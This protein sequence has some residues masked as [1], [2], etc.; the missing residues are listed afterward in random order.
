LK[1]QQDGFVQLFCRQRAGVVCHVESAGGVGQELNAQTPVCGVPGSGF[2]AIL[3]H[4]PGDDY[5][6]D[7]A[8]EEPLR[9]VRACETGRQGLFDQM[10]VRAARDRCVQ[11]KSVTALAKIGEASGAVWRLR[12]WGPAC[13]TV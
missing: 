9:Q 7:A 1:D 12:R 13:T 2:I 4:V 10:V 5:R 11:G 3:G 6:V 8:F